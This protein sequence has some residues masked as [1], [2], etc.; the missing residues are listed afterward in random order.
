MDS[1]ASKKCLVLGGGGFIGTNLCLALT[2]KV[3]ELRAFGRRQSF[4]AS[5]QDVDWIPGD[6]RDSGAVAAA[7]SGCDTVFHLISGSTPVSG[8][9][10]MTFD[11]QASVSS[12][13]HLLEACR[14]QSVK[15]V[16]FVSSGGA[17]YGVPEITPTPETA[18]TNPISAYG[19]TKLTI[20]KYLHL[21]EHHHGIE[22][23]V[24]RVANPFGPYQTAVRGQGVIAAFLGKA[25]KNEPVDIY[26]DGSVIRDYL[27]IDDVVRAIIA[28]TTHDGKDR[29]FNIASGVGRDLLSLMKDIE[30]ILGRKIEVRRHEG[31]KVDVPVSV[32]DISR[33]KKVL[34]WEPRTEFT[35]GLEKTVEWIKRKKDGGP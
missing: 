17:V 9:I 21:F 28:G 2:G 24:L 3:A 30:A 4:P 35:A 27:Y 5:L 31:R 1:L 8:N 29:I 16:I 26:G 11:I 32:L 7:L 15:K 33:A 12:T 18:P 34:S 19:I 13:I 22:Y 20:E 23:R 25:M 14:A 10:D 6:F